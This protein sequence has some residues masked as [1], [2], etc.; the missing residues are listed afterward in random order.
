[1]SES[2][3]VKGVI[4]VI[5]DAM[6]VSQS[7]RKREFVIEVVDNNYSE[8]IQLEFIQDKCEILNQYQVGMQVNVKFN[9][10]GRKWTNPQG[11][12]K[13]FNT[14]QAWQISSVGQQQQLPRQQ[15]TKEQ[16]PV[17][18]AYNPNQLIDD[19]PF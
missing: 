3:Q 13:Y 16:Q 6:Q 17:M 5:G 18:P 14:L 19:V 9:L 7:F 10:K 15:P 2:Y 4:A 11:V 1:M 8:L 12:D